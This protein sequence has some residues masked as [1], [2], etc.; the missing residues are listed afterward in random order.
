VT[1]AR[2]RSPIKRHRTGARPIVSRRVAVVRRLDFAGSMAARPSPAAA[3]RKPE[4]MM[5]GMTMGR[6]VYGCLLP[7]S[8]MMK[9]IA[10]TIGA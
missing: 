7:W 6:H 9:M 4:R 10:G 3:I 1:Y 5:R 2:M 8:R